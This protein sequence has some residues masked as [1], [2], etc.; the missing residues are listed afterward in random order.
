MVGND[1]SG[2]VDLNLDL[3]KAVELALTGGWDLQPFCD[4]ITGKRVIAL[5]AR[6]KQ[7]KLR[8]DE[9]ASRVDLAQHVE[10]VAAANAALVD[11]PE[12]R[13]IFRAASA[14]R[15]VWVVEFPLFVGMSMLRAVGFTAG[16][17]YPP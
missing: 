10:H 7:A 4:P 15:Y 3:L 8:G 6:V 12:A 2:T 14:N 1:R 11:D 13:T 5:N 16:P 9:V 17:Q